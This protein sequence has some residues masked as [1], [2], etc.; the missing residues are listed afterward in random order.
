MRLASMTNGNG[1]GLAD[2]VD[3]SLFLFGKSLKEM[4]FWDNVC[5]LTHV[6]KLESH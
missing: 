1:L 6:I 3:L 2:A 4:H 5:L